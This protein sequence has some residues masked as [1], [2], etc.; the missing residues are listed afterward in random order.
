MKVMRSSATRKTDKGYK[1][2]NLLLYIFFNESV[3]ANVL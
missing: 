3:A 1:V 2:N